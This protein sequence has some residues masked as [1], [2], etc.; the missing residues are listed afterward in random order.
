MDF[1]QALD[2]ILGFA[3]FERM[4]RTG[5][6]FDLKRIE[7]LLARLGNPELAAR[8]IHVT[9]TKGKG[10]TSAMTA[11]ILTKS[12]Y[13]TGLYTSPHLLSVTERIMFDGRPISEI[14]FAALAE[15]LKPDIDEV[16]LS[17]G[18]GQLTTFEILTAMAFV[19]FR[20]IKADYQVV[21]VGLGG[22]LDATNVVHPEVCVIT[23]ISYDHME[24]LGNTLAE[25]ASEK[26]GIIKPGADVISAP[27]TS[28]AATVIE[29]ACREKGVRL[30]TAGRDVT[31]QRKSFTPE[32][33][34][35]DLTGPGWEYSNLKIPLLGEYQMEN[36]ACVAA[37]AEC[38]KQR[39]ARI[40]SASLRQ[41]LAATNWPGRMQILRKHPWLVIDG[42]HNAYS[43]K[44]LMAG[45]REYFRFD[46]LT[47]IYGASGDKHLSGMIAEIAP[48]SDRVI[49]ASAHHPRAARPDLIL[50]EFKKNGKT[51]EI[52]PEVCEALSLA[53]FGA[54][55]NDLICA[56][57]SIFMIAELMQCPGAG[58]TPPG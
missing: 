9:G 40:T 10:S 49:I 25:I 4:P 7:K 26:A 38:L 31:W 55:T 48:A 37:A 32:G 50:A 56:T 54:G 42:A 47:V 36:A 22:R 5:A 16:N 20:E 51:A 19:H 53:L 3:D 43:M 8:T 35:F 46:R 29:K 17:G 39:G 18:V 41:G 24:V 34:T 52:C 15:R 58:Q 6:I 12:G 13:R 11:S 30:I 23:S 14:D 45:L 44:R 27:Q 21:E 57:G 1:N 33:Q 2:Y 28:E